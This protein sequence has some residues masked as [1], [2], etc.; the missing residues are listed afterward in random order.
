M[1]YKPSYLLIY[2]DDK[3]VEQLLETVPFRDGVIKS[4]IPKKGYEGFIEYEHIY[5]KLRKFHPNAKN[6]S[7]YGLRG[8]R[9]A[10]V[11]LARSIYERLNRTGDYY[12]LLWDILVPMTSPYSVVGSNE[13][14]II[15]LYEELVRFE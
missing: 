7:F 13:P 5:L 2:D 3:Y 8:N 12:E 6:E 14:E 9:V 11:L 1:A 15:E 4:F 10:K